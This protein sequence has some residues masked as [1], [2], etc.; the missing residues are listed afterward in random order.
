MNNSIIKKKYLKSMKEKVWNNEE[1]N[2][3]VS[4][5]LSGKK[6]TIEHRKKLSISHIGHKN[7]ENSKEKNRQKQ[8]EIM[9]NP[10]N[11][12]NL[13][14]KNSLDKHPQWKG[15]ISFEPYPISFNRKLKKLIRE[16]DNFK[17]IICKNIGNIVHHIDYNKKNCSPENLITLCRSC[18]GKTIHNR[19][20][21]RKYFN[22]TK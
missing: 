21:W 3:K 5:K 11:R 16:R 2:K 20:T 6:K 9:K 10:K 1:R 13:S 14:I 22:E 7:S 12:L 17:C 8:K 19:S 15:G 18:H 4:I